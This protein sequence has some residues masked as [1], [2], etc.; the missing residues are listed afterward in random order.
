MTAL[1][2][3]AVDEHEGVPNVVVELGSGGGASAGCGTFSVQQRALT[4]VADG[5]AGRRELRVFWRKRRLRCREDICA[6]GSFARRRA[7]TSPLGPG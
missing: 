3:L 5:S 2:F 7:T 4:S 1:A 6:V